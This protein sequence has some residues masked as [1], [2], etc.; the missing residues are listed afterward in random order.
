VLAR[1]ID[2]LGVDDLRWGTG[3]GFRYASVV[4]P[5]RLDLTFRPLYPED[6]GPDQFINCLYKDREPRTIDLANDLSDL[7]GEYDPSTRRLPVMVNLYLA[8]GEAF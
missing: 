8:I 7:F 1:T 5:I 6:A 2:D 4:G 3:V